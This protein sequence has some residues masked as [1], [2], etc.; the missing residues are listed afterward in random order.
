M[1]FA[2]WSAAACAALTVVNLTS[3]AL[4]WAR[5]RP[6]GTPAGAAAGRPPVSILRPVCGLE[7]FLEETLRT[8]FVLDYPDYELI[9]C[10]ER[11]EDPVVPLVRR[12]IAA[13]PGIPARLL[14]GEDRISANPKLN[15]LVK[16]WREARHGWVVLADSNVLM[17]PDYLQRLLE[18]WRAKTGLV[19][20]TPLGVRP[21]S[22]WAW[23]ECAFLNTLQARWQYAGEAA[24]QGFAQGKSMLWRR[25][26]LEAQGGIRALASELAEDAAATKLVR[27]AG[28]RVHLVDAPFEQPLGPRGAGPV[29]ARQLRWARLR[30][31]TF[32]AF[33]A[34]ESLSGAAVPMALAL[35]AAASAGVSLPGTALLVALLWYG[36]ETA[37]A[38]RKGWPLSWRLVPAMMVRD[39]MIPALWV[40]A[41]GGGRT[42]WRGNAMRIRVRAAEAGAPG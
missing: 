9:F 24:G 4:A 42:V 3:I 36:A 39:A 25:D 40:S 38:A 34:P 16:G 29:W 15:N 18:A 11:E 17:P 30:R 28:R 21:G 33:F 14:V 26:F 37:L 32:P 2:L 19:C 13:H 5:L 35:A 10:V 20:S 8:G 22:G 7:A 41:W 31:V 6:S 12:L 1:S 27:A 23:V